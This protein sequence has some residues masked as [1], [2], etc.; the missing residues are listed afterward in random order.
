MAQQQQLVLEFIEKVKRD[1]YRNNDR[2]QF[3]S[4]TAED[5]Y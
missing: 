3:S 1:N 2:E 5:A 4:C